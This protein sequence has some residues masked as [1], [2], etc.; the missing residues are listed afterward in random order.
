P[1]YLVN[2]GA[3]IRGVDFGVHKAPDSFASVARIYDRMRRVIELAVER[4]LPTARIADE[5]AEE[6]LQ[7]RRARRA[8]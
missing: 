4:H 2:A 6:G 1:D 3:L 7:K 8:T 5:L